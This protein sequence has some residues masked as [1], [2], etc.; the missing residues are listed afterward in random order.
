M[1]AFPITGQPRIDV[2]Y[3]T[4]RRRYRTALRIDLGRPDPTP[5]MPDPFREIE[6]DTE[7][8]RPAK[9]RR[10]KGQPSLR[11]KIWQYIIDNPGSTSDKFVSEFGSNLNSVHNALR[12]LVDTGRVDYTVEER[13]DSRAPK[14]YHYDTG[15][16][17][18]DDE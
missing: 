6:C 12:T 15:R 16:W 8:Q 2:Y 17:S 9:L 13:T 1:T 14:H 3:C 7:R 18:I 4:N 11:H 10:Y 5:T